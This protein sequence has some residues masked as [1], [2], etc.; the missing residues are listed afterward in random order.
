M[1]WT[2]KS[3]II[4]AAA[5]ASVANAQIA[6]EPVMP[7]GIIGAP[8]GTGKY[9]A[10][11]EARAD[12][13]DHTFYHPAKLPKEKLPLLLW[14][15]GG[16]RDNGLSASHFL[17]EVASHGYFIITA[18]APRSER[19]VGPLVVPPTTATPTAPA[20][21][22]APPRM[23]TDATQPSQL[24]DAIDWATRANADKTSPFYRRIDVSRIAVS[25]HSCGGLQTIAVAADPRIKA[26]MLFNSGV[27]N[28]S[29]IGQSALQI[30]K[31]AL[32]K[33]HTPV[34]YF[35]GG[36]SDI[37][38]ANA[39]DDFTRINHVPIFNGNF[40]V[41]HGG[42]FWNENGGLWAQMG[43]Y[44]L[45]WQLKGDRAAGRWFSGK[46]CVLCR[47]AKWVVKR[48]KLGEK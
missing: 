29:R 6:P 28:D 44:W 35:I 34:A 27:L 31:S 32:I 22:P 33:L 21:L 15:N 48:K 23:V 10:V 14:G 7:P 43:V 11:A 39:E 20:T 18:G 5:I 26:A 19:P 2:L 47:D 12:Y 37:A 1:A 30:G 25:G 40:N 8:A 4:G 36:P 42:T 24:I 45:D 9:P 46:D 41:G 17:R 38:Y 16:C 13:A 3:L